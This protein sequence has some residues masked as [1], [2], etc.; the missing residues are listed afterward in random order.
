MTGAALYDDGG[1]RLDERGLTIRRYYFPFA[2]S[3]RIPYRRLHGV[4]RRKMT[5]WGGKGRLWGTSDPRYWLPLD[6]RR[7]T[8]QWLLILDVGGWV[9]PVISPDDAQ[10]VEAILREQMRGR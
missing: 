3:K 10:Q 5:V 6:V 2:S 1:V 4:E 9:R 7:P 8:K